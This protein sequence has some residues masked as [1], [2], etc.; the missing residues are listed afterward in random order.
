[1]FYLEW[2]R[3]SLAQVLGTGHDV[4]APVEVELRSRVAVRK[5]AMLD[6]LLGVCR[7]IN[8]DCKLLKWLMHKFVITQLINKVHVYSLNKRILNKPG[9]CEATK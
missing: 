2:V 3:F 8:L 9:S 4:M 7:E 1:M 5:S 6:V